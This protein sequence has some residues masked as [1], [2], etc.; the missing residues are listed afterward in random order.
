M[1]SNNDIGGRRPPFRPLRRRL[2]GSGGLGFDRRDGRPAATS[3]RD[4]RELGAA[5]DLPPALAKTL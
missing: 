1:P 4:G 3:P 5:G 2:G